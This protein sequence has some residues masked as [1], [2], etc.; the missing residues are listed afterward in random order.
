[1]KKTLLAAVMFGAIATPAHAEHWDVISTKLKDGCTM[2]KY[3]EIV[4]D[5]NAWAKPY[6]YHATILTPIQAQDLTTFWW[7]GVTENTAKFGE[8]WDTWRDAL[9]DPNSAPSKLQ[10]RFDACGTDTSRT[11]YDAQ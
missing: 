8:T 4:K 7:I 2:G 9:A 11:G 1:M 3:M 10:T 5:F 6:G